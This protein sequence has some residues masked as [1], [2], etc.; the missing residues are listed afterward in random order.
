[1]VF[2]VD[3]T[4]GGQ[5]GFGEFYQNFLR[6]PPI[7]ISSDEDADVAQGDIRGGGDGKHNRAED[8]SR[9]CGV[10]AG[11]DDA[12]VA[13]AVDRRDT[14]GGAEVAGHSHDTRGGADEVMQEMDPIEETSSPERDP[15]QTTPGEWEKPCLARER[16]P[17]PTKWGRCERCGAPMRAVYPAASGASAFLGCTKFRSTDPNSCRFTR[18]VPADRYHELPDRVVVRRTVH[19]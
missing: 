15:I 14:R 2:S 16:S 1:M 18:G 7:A 3:L 5:H 4:A 10:G 6:C 13:A 17:R 9:Q 11:Q 19:G 8:P 12:S